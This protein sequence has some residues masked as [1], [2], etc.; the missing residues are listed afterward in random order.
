MVCLQ[1]RVYARDHAPHGPSRRQ[2]RRQH[3]HLWSSRGPDGDDY[4]ARLREDFRH[5][6]CHQRPPRWLG[7]RHSVV[8]RGPALGCLCH[9]H[10]RPLRLLR[11]PPAAPPP[12][13]RRSPRRLSH[14]RLLRCFRGPLRRDLL[15]GQVRSLGWIPSPQRQLQSRR[16]VRYP[17][18]RHPR[19]CCLVLDHVRHHLLRAQGDCRHPR[20]PGRRERGPRPLR[21]RRQ[22]VFRQP[23]QQLSVEDGQHRSQRPW[24]PGRSPTRRQPPPR[25]PRGD[26]IGASGDPRRERGSTVGGQAPTVAGPAAK[27]ELGGRG[28]GAGR[29]GGAESSSASPG[30]LGGRATV[31]RRRREAEAKGVKQAPARQG[32]EGQQQQ[33]AGGWRHGERRCAIAGQRAEPGAV[34]HGR[35]QSEGDDDDDVCVILLLKGGPQSAP[36]L[37]GSLEPGL[38]RNFEHREKKRL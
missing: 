17:I 24:L 1:L 4:L 6:H 10:H 38:T 2:D 18:R 26:L 28:S 16:A 32:R 14:P 21:T 23:R 9:R 27:P 20:A 3:D 31:R 25:A 7:G 5:R 8:C 12:A 15:P 33:V 37:A 29:V 36:R 22:R 13:D 19:H 34:G 11:R 35:K 30:G